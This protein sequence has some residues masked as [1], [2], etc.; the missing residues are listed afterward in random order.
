MR[1]M[2]A[3]TIVGGVQSQLWYHSTDS[4]TPFGGGTQLDAPPVDHAVNPAGFL[5]NNMIGLAGDWVAAGGAAGLPAEL[6]AVWNHEHGA[7]GSSPISATA[8]GESESDHDTAAATTATA[9]AT[10]VAAL[11][12]V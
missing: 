8:I 1:V 9:A 12:V 11:R 4:L 7:A 5:Q 3:G 2:A 10:R 6:S